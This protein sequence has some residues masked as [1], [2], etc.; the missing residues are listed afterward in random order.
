MGDHKRKKTHHHQGMEIMWITPGL[1]FVYFGYSG[2]EALAF[3]GWM[4]RRWGITSRH[5]YY[6]HL[7]WVFLCLILT[8]FG[9]LNL[10]IVIFGL[11]DQLL[12]PP[13]LCTTQTGSVHKIDRGKQ[14]VN[15]RRNSPPTRNVVRFYS[16][17]TGVSRHG[18]TWRRRR[19]V[20]VEANGGTRR[21]LEVTRSRTG[22][23]L[24]WGTLYS[25]M[26]P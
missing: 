9:P 5:R 4:S 10:A 23:E 1:A 6:F 25:M 21:P 17:C 26:F 19:R 16:A 20:Y 15:D 11:M 2:R 13:R 8:G 22:T 24:E 7:V 12:L 3:G 14:E 18:I